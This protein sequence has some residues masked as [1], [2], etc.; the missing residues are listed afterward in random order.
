MSKHYD[1]VVLGAGV[2]ALSAAALLAR[3]S[4]RV[5]VLGQGWRP[6]TYAWNGLPLARRTFSF[7]AG[8]TPVWRRILI[9]LAQSQ[10]FRRHVRAP[11]PM[12]Q[13]LDARLRISLPSD[14]VL[15][16]REIDREFSE[17]RR[18]VDDLYAEI[19]RVNE[20]ADA[21]FEQDVVWSPGT[22]WE[23]RETARAVAMLPF[24]RERE[25][26]LVAEF[27]RGHAFRSIVKVPAT[28]AA[29][30]GVDL[31]PLALARLYGAWTRGLLE[32]GRGDA[33]LTEFLTERVR[34]HG[35]EVHLSG[36]ASEIATR[37][38]RA[39]GVRIDGDDEV[40][41]VQF[42]VTD[43][44][45]SA[46][47]DLAPSYRP[48]RR[49]EVGRPRIEVESQRFVMSMLVR[50]EGVPAALATEAFLLPPT[51]SDGH[52]VH[53]QRS[54]SPAP[55][56][57]LLVAE[58]R[59]GPPETFG[60]RE[61]RV[62]RASMVAS[63]ERYLPYVERHTLLVDSPHDGLPLWDY[64]SGARVLVDRTALRGE[65]GSIEPETMRPLVRVD[66][67]AASSLGGLEGESLRYPL[68]STFGVGE[69][70]LP[71][72]GQEGELLA[73]WGSARII[74]RTDRHKEKMRREMWNKVEL[75]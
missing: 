63:I 54:A 29:N 9:E 22:F 73:A 64:R 66:D 13:V 33:E 15:R 55:G 62:V 41:G 8:T 67:R 68:G 52:V 61:R 38:G 1:V 4:W 25:K 11:D 28:F 12:F 26:D 59:V 39:T 24:R 57:T 18:L 69:T 10:A 19:G 20:A 56:T 45:S 34:A 74:T 60:A 72:L 65:G 71:G 43:L 58:V 17:V 37:S 30:V 48:P 36:R 6:A 53:L 21:A 42:V 7:L 40:T 51:G 32:F 27:P 31:P 70:V 44:P 16:G 2:G 35:G 47:V 49:A 3:R 46:L 5:L 14:D 50:D 75:G 23:R